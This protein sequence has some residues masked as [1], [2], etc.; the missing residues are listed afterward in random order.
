MLIVSYDFFFINL[1]GLISHN[2]KSY[3]AHWLDYLYQAGCCAYFDVEN[4]MDPSLTEAMG[5]D[6]ENLLFLRPSSAENLLNAVDTLTKSC[7]VDVI[8]V[9]SV[10]SCSSSLS[11]TVKRSFDYVLF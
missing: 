1:K 9:D 5:I 8:V 6:T 7:S 2:V 11:L 3:W 4:A 10:S